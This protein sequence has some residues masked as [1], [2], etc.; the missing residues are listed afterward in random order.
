MLSVLLEPFKVAVITHHH[1]RNT[2]TLTTDGLIFKSKLDE[3]KHQHTTGNT[4][5][6]RIG[7]QAFQQKG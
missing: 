1:Q 3:C 7:I 6:L 4:N 2:M 5:G